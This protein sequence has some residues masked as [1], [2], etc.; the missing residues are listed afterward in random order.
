MIPDMRIMT[1]SVLL[2]TNSMLMKVSKSILILTIA[3]LMIHESSAQDFIPLWEPG[4]MPNTKGL[5]L[6]DSI[7]NERIFQVGTPGMY[8]FFPSITENKRAAVVICPGGGY[9]RLAYIVSGTQIAKWFNSIGI[10]AF[11]LNYRLPTS[12]DLVDKST[13]PIMD[14]QRALKYIRAHAAAWN[15]DTTKIGILGS[16]AGGHL[17]ATAGTAPKDYSD[18]KDSISAHSYKPDFMIL[19]SPVIDMDTYAHQ[20]SRKNL[21]GA[22]PTKAVIA[23]N[24][25]QLNVSSQTP[26]AF[27][28]HANNDKSV[29]PKNSILFFEALSDHN[30]PASIHIFQ[31]GGHAINISDNPGSTQ[32][33]PSLCAAWLKES[34]FIKQ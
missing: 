3:L 5:Q 1:G 13:G 29:N 34:G 24:S 16:S 6:K 22:S 14:A 19:I 25:P 4:K 28:V 26:P 15:I 20:G 18:L 23:F 21:L 2:P 33:W 12:P 7:S 17:A 31:Q 30:I 32:Q 9:E 11:V 8:P 10:T 27:I